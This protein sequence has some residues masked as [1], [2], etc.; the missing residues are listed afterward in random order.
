MSNL[1]IKNVRTWTP[2]GFKTQDIELH[3]E[4]T[5]SPL[6]IDGT[7]KYWLPPLVELFADF[8]EPGLEHIYSLHEGAEA[9]LSGGFGSVILDPNTHPVADQQEVIQ[10]IQTQ[11]Q[12]LELD[13]YPCGALTKDQKGV[14][15]AEMSSMQSEGAQ[16]FSNGV[17][18]MPTAP[19][20]RSVFEYAKQLDV[21]L[22]VFPWQQDIC[23]SGL[24]HE[25]SLSSILGLQGWPSAAERISVM[26]ALELAELTGVKLHLRQLTLASSIELVERYQ[27]MGVKVSFDV[28]PAHIH[29]NNEHLLKLDVNDKIIPPLRGIKDQL[30]VYELFQQG[31]IPILSSQHRPVLP[32]F[33]NE[34]FGDSKPGN[35]SLE[36]CLPNF[37]QISDHKEKILNQFII[38]HSHNP[39][40]KLGKKSAFEIKGSYAGFL[41]DPESV[42][43]VNAGTFAGN[44]DNSNELG[45]I[46]KWKV[47]A[48]YLNNSFKMPIKQ[49]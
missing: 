15:L 1:F 28:N 29:R 4:N 47:E 35:L 46:L 37:I 2:T 16:F 18:P 6:E 14:H 40:I 32:E 26:T 20:L 7:G 33:K 9:M 13:I 3:N 21:E 30:E 17:R 43:E 5:E 10:W 25:D 11:T 48:A 38:S 23:G 34:A 49:L 8:K 22:M 41:W 44:V 42:Q 36:L 19:I 45:N 31:R 24:V 39:S 12:K 27:K